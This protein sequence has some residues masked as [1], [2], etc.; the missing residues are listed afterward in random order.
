VAEETLRAR[1]GAHRSIEF[2]IVVRDGRAIVKPI[3][4]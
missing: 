4:R 1:H 3:V 2:D